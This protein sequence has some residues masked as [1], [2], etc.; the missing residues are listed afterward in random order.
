MDIKE[1]KNIYT[2][3]LVDDHE[4]FRQ[5]LKALIKGFENLSIIGSLKDGKQLVEFLKK[6]I[7]D[8][9]IMDIHM[10]FIDGIE[11]TKY[12]K[13]LLPKVKIIALTMDSDRFTI[14]RAFKA[15]ASAFLTKSITQKI[16]C[17]ALTHVLANKT[18]ISAD[19]ALN[20]SLGHLKEQE[21]TRSEKEIAKMIKAADT[22]QLDTE[23]SN[24]EI[25]IVKLI[26][27]GF[28][29]LEI[30][31]KMNLSPRSIEKYRSRMMKKLKVKNSLELV[32]LVMDKGLI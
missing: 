1:S 9:I 12:V 16:F 17:E 21:V 15:G 6:R 23:L 31:E 18:Y 24:Q 29:S 10:P 5:G 11:A 32:R 30:G 8:I 7:P 28:T 3:V 2:V 25:E 13:A 26:S 22:N 19:A 20:Y 14:D 4:I 27:I